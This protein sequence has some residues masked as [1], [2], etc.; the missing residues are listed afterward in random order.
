MA[1]VFSAPSSLTGSR[2]AS[3]R[4]PC[5][6][7]FLPALRVSESVSVVCGSGEFRGGVKAAVRSVGREAL[8]CGSRVTMAASAEVSSSVAEAEPRPFGVLFVCLGNICRSPTAEAV[9]R[10]VVEKRKLDSLFNIDS[11]GTIDYHEGNPADPRMKA[12]ALKRGVKLT[13]ISRP[14]RSSDFEEFDLI[15]AMD[16][17]NRA[18]IL[19]AYESWNRRAPLPAGSKE[20]VKLMCSY[21]TK[22]NVD[23]VPDPYYGGPAGFEKVLDLLEDACEGLLASIQELQVKDGKVDVKTSI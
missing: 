20:K 21:C 7:V 1:S 10:D 2:A 12:A 17:S 8:G 4:V 15:L 5:R 3:S 16:K 14:I 11:A 18:D 13:S 23:E 19:T 22:H 9:F 6:S